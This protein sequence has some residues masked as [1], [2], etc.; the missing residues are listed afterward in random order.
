MNFSKIFLQSEFKKYVKF[1][2]AIFV[3][4]F[5]AGGYFFW[6]P[7][8]QEYQ[9]NKR[10]LDGKDEEIKIKKEYLRELNGHLNNIMEY[11]EELLMIE[12][13]VP[14]GYSLPALYSFIQSLASRN[15]VILTE[16]GHQL[17][18]AGT[19]VESEGE[20]LTDLKKIGLS[21]GVSGEYSSLKNFIAALHKN[22]RFFNINKLTFSSPGAGE[23][24]E[25]ELEDMFDFSLGFE[26]VYYE[27]SLEEL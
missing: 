3:L 9:E 2:L 11:G 13:G 12:E 24:E 22:S 14:T 18:G 15:R 8:Y 5:L 27:D 19:G 10:I 26:I 1:I 25:S 4:L 23:G 17:G 21:F 16:L 20:V 7:K 6:V